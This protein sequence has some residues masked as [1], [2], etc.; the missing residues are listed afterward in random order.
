MDRKEMDAI[1][2]RVLSALHDDEVP[3]LDEQAVVDKPSYP[4][5]R[6]IRRGEPVL[7]T[8]ESLKKAAPNGG[9]V[10]VEGKV[11]MTPS[12]KDFMRKK[13]ICIEFVEYDAPGGKA[14]G[15]HAEVSAA[16]AIGADHRGFTL[17]ELLKREL[18]KIGYRMLDVGTNEPKSCDY[19][20]FSAAVAR[21]VS[22]GEAAFGIAIDSAGIGS[23]I[24]ANKIKD[25]RAT[26]C[27]DETTAK[28]ARLHNDANVLCIGADKIA[29]AK[30]ITMV[31]QFIKTE[32]VPNERY[33]RRIR[34]IT[35][36]EM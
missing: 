21:K 18:T 28:Q 22:T 12:A 7:V 34:K 35:E 20:D 6:G 29:P 10:I 16:I 31:G 27:W 25:V 32:Y 15:Q 14:I 3:V 4:V 8:E 36:L 19:P 11:I 23:A 5:L 2:S 1:V 33:D 13:N 9:T 26:V 24:A 17:K 30:A